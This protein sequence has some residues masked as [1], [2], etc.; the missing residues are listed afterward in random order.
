MSAKVQEQTLSL[1]ANNSVQILAQFVEIAQQKGA[2]LLQEAETLKR[3]MDVLLANAEDKDVNEVLAKQ[4]LVQGV[5]KG[6]RHGSYSISDAA[7]LSKV[8]QFVI[9]SLPK[10]APAAG[11][12]PG[13]A[14]GS[15][16]GS[17]SGWPGHAQS[18]FAGIAG[19]SRSNGFPRPGPKT[20]SPTARRSAAAGRSRLRRADR[21]SHRRARAAGR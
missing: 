11:S 18:R 14:A 10:E 7:I 6:Q 8:V 17:G 4:L 2:Y 13:S 12:A 1:D 21:C 19:E 5:Q 16:P 15:A 9:D 20:A 3:A